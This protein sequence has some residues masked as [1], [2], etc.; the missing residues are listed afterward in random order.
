VAPKNQ[1]QKCRSTL[2]STVRFSLMYF[3]LRAD[4]KRCSS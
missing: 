4:S 2:F 1:N 3:R